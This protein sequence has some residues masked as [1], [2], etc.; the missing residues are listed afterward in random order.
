MMCLSS[1]Y[2]ILYS[3]DFLVAVK[4]TFLQLIKEVIKM[5]FAVVIEKVVPAIHSRE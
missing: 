4:A 5:S 2:I 1:A 3:D